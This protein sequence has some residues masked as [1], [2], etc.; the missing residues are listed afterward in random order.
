[1][2]VRDEMEDGG[3]SFLRDSPGQQKKA[4]SSISK[5]TVFL[6]LTTQFSQTIPRRMQ[7]QLDES[8]KVR[9]LTGNLRHMEEMS[10]IGGCTSPNKNTM[11]YSDSKHSKK[12]PLRNGLW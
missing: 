5:S 1:V 4:R 10:T 3:E 8:Q 6:R 12:P 7:A 9:P 11:S 2:P